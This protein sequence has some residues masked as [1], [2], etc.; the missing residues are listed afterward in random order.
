MASGFDIGVHDPIPALN[1]GDSGAG[2]GRSGVA[3]DAA[4]GLAI[5]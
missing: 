4:Y 2:L 5:A 1:L 3:L